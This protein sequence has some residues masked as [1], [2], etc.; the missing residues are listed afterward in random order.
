M[1]GCV[2]WPGKPTAKGYARLRVGGRQHRAHRYFWEK[3]NG[4]IPDGLIVMHACD[5]PPCVNVA[6]L[7]LG[8]IADNNRDKVAKGR[9][10]K[11]L[12]PASAKLIEADLDAIRAMRRGGATLVAIARRFDVHNSTISRACRGQSYRLPGL[13]SMTLRG[14]G[15]HPSSRD[16]RAEPGRPDEARP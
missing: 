7:R 10:R 2:V 1:T 5:N 3:E 9:T 15:E 14:A 16:A 6:H 8:T 12:R 13:G 11:G 4:P